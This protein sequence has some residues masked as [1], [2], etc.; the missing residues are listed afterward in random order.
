MT[1][2][3]SRLGYILSP[4]HNAGG[5]L[6]SMGTMTAMS[7]RLGLEFFGAMDIGDDYAT[8]SLG[9]ERQTTKKTTIHFS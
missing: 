9:R 6:P 8:A 3:S 1:A 7:S 4:T 5:H 2:M